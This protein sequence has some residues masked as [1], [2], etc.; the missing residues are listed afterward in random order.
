MQINFRKIKL[1][2]LLILCERDDFVIGI[3]LNKKEFVNCGQLSLTIFDRPYTC[4]LI[5]LIMAGY[6]II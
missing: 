6:Q 3:I 2:L 5:H 4:K 1:Q